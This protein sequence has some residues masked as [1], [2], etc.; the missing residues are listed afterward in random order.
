VPVIRDRHDHD[1]APP[2]H[3]RVLAA[4]NGKSGT[5]IAC[6]V[7]CPLS[8]PRSDNDLVSGDGE[9]SGK[10]TPLITGAAKD[11]NDKVAHIGMVVRATVCHG[12]I[13]ARPCFGSST[14]VGHH[15]GM[16]LERVALLRETLAG[17]GWDERFRALA[18]ALRASVRGPGGLLLLGNPG[19]EPWH[20]AAHL[21]DESRWHDIPT[22]RPTLVRWTPPRD[23]PPHLSVG[24]D[25]ITAARRGEALFVVAPETAPPPLL[26]R[27]ADARHVGATVLALENGDSELSGLAH[28]AI[29]VRPDDPTVS[30]DSAQHLVSLASCEPV[31]RQRVRARLSRFLDV[32]SG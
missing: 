32:L 27:V 10:T 22:L 23:A 28:E 6:G 25:R 15:G 2:G 5:E 9:P 12:S 11:S 16:D 4:L 26:E 14:Q 20:L 19:D 30:F 21:H 13:M 18:K 31:A 17:T 29:T 1:I 3:L 24:L 8:P 7:L